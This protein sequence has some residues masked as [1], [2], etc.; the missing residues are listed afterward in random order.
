MSAHTCHARQC[1]REVP[2]KHLMCKR[3]WFMVPADIRR[4]VWLTYQEGQERGEVAPSE[5]WHEAADAA[6]EAVARKEGLA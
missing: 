4:R 6:I 3:H 1:E 5:A 2:P